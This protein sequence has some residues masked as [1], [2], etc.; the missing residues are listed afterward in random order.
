MDIGAHLH[1]NL[2]LGV[3]KWL[4]S[5]LDGRVETGNQW[6]RNDSDL[7]LNL[8]APQCKSTR[9]QT[10]VLSVKSTHDDTQVKRQE[11]PDASGHITAGL[12]QPSTGN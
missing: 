2:S 7:K 4:V 5:G 12:W 11:P 6:R 8:A 9:F 10:E 3:R 1:P